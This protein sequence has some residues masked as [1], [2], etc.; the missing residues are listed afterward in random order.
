MCHNE[1]L[2]YKCAQEKLKDVISDRI[3]QE[4]NPNL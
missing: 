2:L 4:Y 3:S 1:L